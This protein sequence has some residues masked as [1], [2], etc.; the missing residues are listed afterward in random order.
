MQNSLIA[1][2][3]ELK[4]EVFQFLNKLSIYQNV[5]AKPQTDPATIKAN[6]IAQLT[7]PVRWTYIVKNMLAD[8]VTEFTELGPG[9]V[10]Q[11]LIKKVNP[12]AVVESKSTL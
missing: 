12:E 9:N 10:L 1:A 2:S 5:D 6:L 11:G 4:G 8:G 7:A 3:S